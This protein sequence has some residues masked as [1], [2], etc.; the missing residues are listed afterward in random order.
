MKKS[1]KTLMAGLLIV[2]AALAMTACGG[3]NSELA[4][5]EEMLTNEVVVANFDSYKMDVDAD[6]KIDGLF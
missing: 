3:G 1:T 6:G 2:P 5:A 4:R